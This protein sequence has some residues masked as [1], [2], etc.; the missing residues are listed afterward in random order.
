V[1]GEGEAGGAP[2]AQRKHS[3][4]EPTERILVPFEGEGS[5]T[6]ELSWGQGEIWRAMQRQRSWMPLINVKPLPAGATVEDITAELRFRMSRYQSMRTRLRFD[7]SDRPR[8][9]VS[10]SGVATLE[11][12]DADGDPAAAAAAIENQYAEMNLDLVNDWPLRITVI[13]QQG[14]PTHMVS[15]VCHLATDLFGTLAMT[16]DLADRDPRTGQPRAPAPPMPP[17]EQARRQRTPAARRVSDTAMRYWEDLLKTVPPR[18]FAN[19]AGPRQPRYWQARF[20][21]PALYLATRAI[22]ARHQVGASPV[23]LAAVAVALARVTASNPVLIRVVVSNRFR[24]GLAQSV[25]QV[26][27]TGLSV[28]DVADITFDEAVTRAWRSSLAAYKHAYYDP[29][30]LDELVA[31]LSREQG[32]EIDINCYY[33]DRRMQAQRDSAGPVPAERDLRAAL[34]RTALRWDPPSDRP[35]ERFFVHVDDE[36]GSV[37]IVMSADTRYISPGDME[38]CLRGMEEIAVAAA[39]DPPATTHVSPGEKQPR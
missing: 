20:D 8:Q 25:S 28:I 16:A 23:L 22:D 10:G 26:S 33:N 38:A 17:L 34:P 9:V 39:T 14:T 21:S 11:I 32:E 4:S 2:E 18:R 6:D 36:P 3:V 5:G 30:Q 7:A 19:Q 1:K 37:N 13:R 15:A 31:R 27:Q 24:P 35:S 29:A 12:I